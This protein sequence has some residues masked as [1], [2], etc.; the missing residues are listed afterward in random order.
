MVST[1]NNKMFHY[2]SP[3]TLIKMDIEWKCCFKKVEDRD[4]LSDLLPPQFKYSVSQY[5]LK[6]EA[7]LRSESKF[8]VKFQANICTEA[9][10]KIFLRDFSGISN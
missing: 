8:E 4:V 1:T 6:H 10:W 9:Q 2:H 7:Y 3:C 5:D